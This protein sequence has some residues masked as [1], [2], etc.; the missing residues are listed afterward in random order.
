MSFTVTGSYPQSEETGLPLSTPVEVTFSQEVD[1]DSIITGNFIVSTLAKQVVST[2]PVLHEYSGIN[3]IEDELLLSPIFDGIVKGTFSVSSDLKVVKFVPDSPL[4]PSV[5]HV[6]VLSKNI[7]T[8][9]IGDIVFGEYAPNK[10]NGLIELHGPYN[11]TIDDEIT[12][13]ITKSGGLKEAQFKYWY[14]SDPFQTSMDITTDR[15]IILSKNLIVKFAEA[16]YVEGDCFKANLYVG[17]NLDNFYSWKFITGDGSLILPPIEEKSTTLIGATVIDWDANGHIPPGLSCIQYLG[18]SPTDGSSAGDVPLTTRNFIATFSKVL[19]PATVNNQTVI[20]CITGLG[21]YNVRA[22][23][24]V[25]INKTL[26]VS[27]KNIYIN[28]D[29]GI[30]LVQNQ[31]IIFTFDGIY[32]VKHYRMD[33]IVQAITTRFSPM[34]TTAARIR[35]EI[36]PFIRNIPTDTVNRII[37]N[38]SIEALMHNWKQIDP[39][40]DAWLNFLLGEYAVCRTVEDLMEIVVGTEADGVR[41]KTL[42][43]LRV[44]SHDDKPEIGPHIVLKKA[45]SCS[46]S[47]LTMLHNGGLPYLQPTTTIKGLS[48]PNRPMFG[49]SYL[50]TRPWQWPIGNIHQIIFNRAYV[51]GIMTYRYPLY[52]EEQYVNL[53]IV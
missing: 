53:K 51:N 21:S 25:F 6:V 17:I 23:T 4:N 3:N 31:E 16:N 52:L 43:D 22:G 7:L 49:R 5:Y 18:E 47:I 30:T 14:T 26:S 34:L 29:P 42:G 9:T 11:G 33:R 37:F 36:G 10:G 45:M 38:R 15:N 12:I 27:G 32:T 35:L 39:N 44:A 2:G 20:V 41:E 24:P 50:K 40:G 8:R 13:S 19:D 48:D 46:Q 1:L 28:L